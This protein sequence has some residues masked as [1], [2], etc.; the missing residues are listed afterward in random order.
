MRAAF[1]NSVR[2]FPSFAAIGTKITGVD[3]QTFSATGEAFSNIVLPNADSHN[4]RVL[5]EDDVSL[6]YGARL[7]CCPPIDRILNRM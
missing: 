1:S 6:A 4:E 3:D 2:C 7:T 5:Q